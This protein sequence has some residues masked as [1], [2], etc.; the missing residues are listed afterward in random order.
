[1]TFITDPSKP[2]P[3][4]DPDRLYR[5]SRKPVIPL[6]DGPFTHQDDNDRIGAFRERQT[7]DLD[8]RYEDADGEYVVRRKPFHERLERTQQRMTGQGAASGSDF[9]G[10]RN[11]EREDESALI[12][13]EEAGDLLSNQ[14]YSRKQIGNGDKLIRVGEEAWRNQEGERLA[15][16]GVDE[17]ADFYDET[18]VQASNDEED[19]PLAELLKRR[20]GV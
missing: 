17:L 8:A 18:D 13:D 1:M 4:P 14:D 5:L 20:R 3:P 19:L 10:S 7:A 2:W 15:D 12:S 9:P 6:S 11:V 16:F